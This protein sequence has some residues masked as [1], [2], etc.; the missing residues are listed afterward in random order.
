MPHTIADHL[1]LYCLRQHCIITARA[2]HPRPVRDWLTTLARASLA[3]PAPVLPLPH[4]LQQCHD[5]LLCER[6]YYAD[7][8]TDPTS[9]LWADCV[10]G[11]VDAEKLEQEMAAYDGVLQLLD[12]HLSN[13]PQVAAQRATVL[14]RLWQWIIGGLK[15]LTSCR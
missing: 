14:G 3:S 5:S 1:G 7:H 8:I 10:S 2:L 15:G 13:P 12:R 11:A 4:E 6:R 9:T